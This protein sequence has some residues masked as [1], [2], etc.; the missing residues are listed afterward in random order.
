[1][2]DENKKLASKVK[3][4]NLR[5]TIMKNDFKKVAFFDENPAFGKKSGNFVNENAVFGLFR[6]SD[7][8]SRL[9]GKY[10][11]ENR[12]GESVYIKADKYA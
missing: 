10:R 4:S 1:M 9:T 5:L 2:T 11:L 8:R 12:S 6:I 3:V 7:L